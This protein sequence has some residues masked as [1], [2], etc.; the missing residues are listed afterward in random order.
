MAEVHIHKDAQ[1]MLQKA[2]Q[3]IKKKFLEFLACLMEDGLDT[4]RF[5]IVPMKGKY[6]VYLEAKIGWDYRVLFRES[7][8]S[9]YIRYAG[10]HNDL[11]TA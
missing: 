4:C 2:P 1:K 6:K 8:R 10:T 3:K 7:N 11:E 5:E 9:F